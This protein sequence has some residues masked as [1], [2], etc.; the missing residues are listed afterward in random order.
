M[1]GDTLKKL[2]SKIK[3]SA[4]K[5]AKETGVDKAYISMLEKNKASN[6]SLDV[7]RS[8]CKSLKITMTDFEKEILKDEE[9]LSEFKAVFGDNPVFKDMGLLEKEAI[10]KTIRENYIKTGRFE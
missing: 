1:F 6:P 8:I 9:T 5:L 3:I 4:T 7:F 2:R 10:L